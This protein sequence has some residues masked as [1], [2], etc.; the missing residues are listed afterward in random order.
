M[1]RRGRPVRSEVDAVR[2]QVWAGEVIR[3]Y[4]GWITDLDQM[5]ELQR[6]RK[7]GAHPSSRWSKYRRGLTSPGEGAAGREYVDSVDVLFAGT[8]KIYWHPLW[9]ALRLDLPLTRGELLTL[10]KALPLQAHQSI[11]LGGGNA[12]FWRRPPESIAWRA[13]VNVADPLDRL[14]ALMLL[15]RDGE[16]SQWPE[17]TKLANRFLNEELHWAVTQPLL[18]RSGISITRMVTD[19]V[20]SPSAGL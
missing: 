5:I 17:L 14:G 11:L 4:G 13:I 7:T 20:E 19:W 12:R 9:R 6:N 16:L 3:Q 15:A 8:G 10:Y 2:T 1:T 18:E